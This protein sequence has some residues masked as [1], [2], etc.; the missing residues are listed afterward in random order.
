M[1]DWSNGHDACLPSRRWEFDS[2]I[3]HQLTVNVNRRNFIKTHTAIHKTYKKHLMNWL[4]RIFYLIC[5]LRIYQMNLPRLYQNES[6]GSRQPVRVVRQ[7]YHGRSVLKKDIPTLW[8]EWFRR[9]KRNV[10]HKCGMAAEF[11]YTP[12]TKGPVMLQYPNWQRKSAQT[13]Y[14]VGSNPTWSTT[15]SRTA[16]YN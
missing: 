4:L 16:T 10:N 11:G 13:R 1:W 15:T 9:R 7:A 6:E 5:V 8:Q 12:Y 14:S 3:P 2:P